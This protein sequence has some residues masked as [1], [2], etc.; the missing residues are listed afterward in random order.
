VE[1]GRVGPIESFPERPYRSLGRTPVRAAPLVAGE[2]SIKLSSAGHEPQLLL[3]QVRATAEM[4]VR[5]VLTPA[6]SSYRAAW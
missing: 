3:A 2:Y 4:T 5:G 6:D 1:I